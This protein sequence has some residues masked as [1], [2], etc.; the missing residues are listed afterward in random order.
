MSMKKLSVKNNIQYPIGDKIEIQYDEE[1]STNFLAIGEEK[2]WKR[3]ALKATIVAG[4]IWIF[5]IYR[6]VHDVF[7]R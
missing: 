7:F 3:E 5:V 2:Y 6:L 1:K 4:F